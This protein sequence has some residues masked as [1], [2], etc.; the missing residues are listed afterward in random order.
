MR[1]IFE[2]EGTDAVLLIDASN[3]FTRMNR[4]VAM[5]NIR[6]TCPKVSVY[7]IN[8]YRHPSR[9]FINGGGEISSREG[10]TQGDPL[11]MPLFPYY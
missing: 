3:A 8:M 1:A 10:T 2:E 6:I 7:I 9:L 4:K 11:A 5:H